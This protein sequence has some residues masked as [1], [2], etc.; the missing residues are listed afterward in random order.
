M[1]VV[2]A[3]C[4]GRTASVAWPETA[5]KHAQLAAHESASAP[6]SAEKRKRDGPASTSPA[7][8]GSAASAG[9]A[10]A[11]RPEAKSAKSSPACERPKQ[12]SAVVARLP[13]KL[14]ASVL[15]RSSEPRTR[16]ATARRAL[17]TATAA[18]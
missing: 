8:H 11:S 6:T 17:N 18:T 5:R 12:T 4:N 14:A 2:A 15:P 7:T 16:G 9:E 13:N 10:K 3:A 1:A